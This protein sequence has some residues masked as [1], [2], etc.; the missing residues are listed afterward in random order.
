LHDEKSSGFLELQP[1]EFAE[2]LA[3]AQSLPGT[4]AGRQGWAERSLSLFWMTLDALEHRD[5]SKVDRVFERLIR[6]V[7]G[8]A[9]SIC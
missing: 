1:S 5:V 7:T 2:A 8:F 4:S 3:L 6:L 9:L